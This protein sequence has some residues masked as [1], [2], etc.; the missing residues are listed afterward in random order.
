MDRET[1]QATAHR[2]AQSRKQLEQ[3]S[4]QAAGRQ[5]T[6]LLALKLIARNYF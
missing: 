3:L 5:V 2:V 4:R 1:W 6:N